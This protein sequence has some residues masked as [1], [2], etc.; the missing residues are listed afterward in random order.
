MDLW[1]WISNIAVAIGIIVSLVNICVTAFNWNR[2]RPQLQF[3]FVEDCTSF[4]MPTSQ[5]EYG[6]RNSSTIAFVYVE[7]SNP[8]SLPCTISK[9][10]LSVPGYPDTYC[11]SNHK[12]RDKYNCD[13]STYI[14][15]AAILKLPCNIPPYG[16]VYGYILFPFCPDYKEEKLSTRLTVRTSKKNFTASLDIYPWEYIQSLRDHLRQENTFDPLCHK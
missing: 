13:T 2:S 12:V 9:C 6:Y 11:R 16:F 4:Y 1:L 7:I 5:H 14:E 3:D 8:S 15:G 10:A